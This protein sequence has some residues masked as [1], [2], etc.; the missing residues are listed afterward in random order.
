MIED[1]AI[2]VFGKLAGKAIDR[3]TKKSPSAVGW[4]SKPLEKHPDWRRLTIQVYA[5]DQPVYI[6]QIEC[7]GATFGLYSVTRLRD[8]YGTKRTFP[9]ASQWSQGSIKRSCFVEPN[10]HKRVATLI[11]PPEGIALADLTITVFD[12][13]TRSLI[14]VKIIAV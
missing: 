5:V 8:R 14:P 1:V 7:Q 2:P 6:S 11:A 9:D 4:F 10:S 3:L 13:V 12:D